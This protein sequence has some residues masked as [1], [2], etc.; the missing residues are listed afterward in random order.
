[1]IE[2][3]RVFEMY[4]QSLASYMALLLTLHMARF[5]VFMALSFL[6]KTI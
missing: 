3:V 4:V 5:F 2:G 1:V 6:T